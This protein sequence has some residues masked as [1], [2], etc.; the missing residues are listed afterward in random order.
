MLLGL[1]KIQSIPEKARRTRAYTPET[2]VK[3]LKLIA[4]GMEV[5][6]V[7]LETG[8][9]VSTLYHWRG[10]PKSDRL[11]EA[12]VRRAKMIVMMECPITMKAFR[13]EFDVSDGTIYKDITAIR[14]THEVTQTSANLA[15]R[16]TK[17]YQ[18]IGED[19]C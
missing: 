2:K 12:K 9:T 4:D 17:T 15:R 19:E 6:D 16:N 14:E 7:S 5:S 10:T 11:A 13:K 3:A 18:I 8:V 1:S